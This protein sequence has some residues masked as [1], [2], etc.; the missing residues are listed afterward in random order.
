MCSSLGTLHQVPCAA[1]VKFGTKMTKRTSFSV[2]F[3]RPSSTLTV[4]SRQSTGVPPKPSARTSAFDCK[5][6]ASC[7]ALTPVQV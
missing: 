5:F 7:Q 4:R 1:S 3:A 6:N 2:K